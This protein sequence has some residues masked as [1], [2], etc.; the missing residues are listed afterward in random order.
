MS[1]LSEKFV[2]VERSMRTQLLER[3]QEIHTAVLA[4]VT[5]YHHFQ[6]GPPGVAKSMLVDTLCDHIDGLGEGSLFSYLL[7]KFT[8]PEEIVGYLDLAAFKEQGLYR[9]VTTRRL[10]EAQIVFLDE[11]FNG[12]SAIL[13]SLLKALNERKFD[14]GDKLL[15]IPL[16]SCFAASNN[17]PAAA[18]LNALADRLHFW[19][20]VKPIQDP[21]NR[22]KLLDG[23]KPPSIQDFVTLE[24]IAAAKAEVDAVTVPEEV[25]NHTLDI[26]DN[27]RNSDIKVS[28]R[29]SR[30]AMRVVRA[31]AWMAGRDTANASDLL[32]LQHMFWNQEQHLE[33]VYDEV[34]TVAAPLD[35]KTRDIHNEI[36]QM[37]H[38]FDRNAKDTTETTTLRRLGMECLEKLRESQKEITQL[39]RAAKADGLPLEAIY[40]LR[41][42]HKEKVA[43]VKSTGF[44]LDETDE[45]DF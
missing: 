44:N 23:W 41:D 18:E 2:K 24:E 35:R 4:L 12:S 8:T 5:G 27:L 32:P 11:A 31:E 43:H 14:R 30:Q 25:V 3:D 45:E 40:A 10:P 20:S 42:F 6:Y 13:N 36:A 17:I 38:E 15:D 34:A 28:D 16:M 26:L 33:K 9:K 37:I 29:R 19:H 1:N 21:S 39:G 22:A 7:T